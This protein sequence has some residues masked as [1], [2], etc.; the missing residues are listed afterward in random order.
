MCTRKTLSDNIPRHH[1]SI[2]AIQLELWAVAQ[3][4]RNP[5]LRSKNEI[6]AK[7]SHFFLKNTPDTRFALSHTDC[8]AHIKCIFAA[9]RT[10]FGPMGTLEAYRGP[11]RGL[12]GITKGSRYE[13]VNG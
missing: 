6:F 5:L 12:F 11:S 8:I 2:H 7:I 1:G 9:V 13:T 4:A 3:V 10:G